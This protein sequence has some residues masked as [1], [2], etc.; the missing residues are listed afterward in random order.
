MTFLHMSHYL[1]SNCN[2]CVL[3][4]KITPHI[5]HYDGWNHTIYL[6]QVLWVV[7]FCVTTTIFSCCYIN[8]FSLIVIS[9]LTQGYLF[10]S[11]WVRIDNIDI[12]KR[13]TTRPCI[14]NIIKGA[15]IQKIKW[16]SMS[17]LFWANPP[18]HSRYAIIDQIFLSYKLRWKI[19]FPHFWK[20]KK[21]KIW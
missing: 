15:K 18:L 3:Y 6:T 11:P 7:V 16:N 1:M 14:H 13:T 19:I 8:Y 2:Y 4:A 20:M 17:F 12:T 5:V 10:F 21:Y 9:I